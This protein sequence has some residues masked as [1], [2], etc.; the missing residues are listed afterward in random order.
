VA[1]SAVFYWQRIGTTISIQTNWSRTSIGLIP[2]QAGNSPS[3]RTQGFGMASS[4]SYQWS[5]PG[6][7]VKNTLFSLAKLSG[8]FVFL[9]K[10]NVC[11]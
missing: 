3:D 4:G 6:V 9:A 8:M 11:E 7:N 1:I 5:H 2:L 10:F